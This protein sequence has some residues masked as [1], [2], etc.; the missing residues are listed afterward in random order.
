[1]P[2]FFSPKPI[3]TSNPKSLSKH[4]VGF[5]IALIT[6]ILLLMGIGLAYFIDNET[7]KKS[8]M[9][10]LEKTGSYIDKIIG[11]Q[12]LRIPSSWFRFTDQ[13][14]DEFS[15][16]IDL[17]FALALGENNSLAQVNVALMPRKAALPSAILLDSVY[18]RQ[19][20]NEQLSGMNG[21]IGKPLK[22]SE[23]FD[24][25]T[26]WY[27]PL[28]ANPFVAKCIAPVADQSRQ[29]CIRTIFLSKKISATYM[30][31]IELLK[32]WKRFDSEATKWFGKIDG[33]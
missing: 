18:L 31:D 8:S 4:D 27:D 29:Q 14:H 9:P 25:E 22:P 6:L 12:K 33:L 30:F 13:H 7:K 28:S 20:Q 19:F 16:Q 10:S 32:N 23:G 11:G 24:K 15:K 17:S 26:I 1:M 21:L 5:N 2:S 3:K